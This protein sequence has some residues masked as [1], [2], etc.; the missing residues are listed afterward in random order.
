[1]RAPRP[2]CTRR[3]DKIERNRVAECCWEK[4]RRRRREGQGGSHEGRCPC[5]RYVSLRLF[6]MSNEYLFLSS[7]FSTE[8]VPSLPCRDASRM[9][10][11]RGGS[12]GSGSDA[13]SGQTGQTDIAVRWI[14]LSRDEIRAIVDDLDGLEQREFDTG[15]WFPS[16]PRIPDLAPLPIPD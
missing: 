11:Q 3:A 2:P 1:M 4:R 15:G 14:S 16:R 6:R 12:R 8:V 9:R 13:S 5:A 7:V 10:P